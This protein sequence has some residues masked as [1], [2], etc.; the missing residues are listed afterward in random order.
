MKKIDK[1]I[2]DRTLTY[3]QKNRDY[4]NSVDKTRLIFGKQ[5]DLVR[6]ADKIHRIEQLALKHNE[7]KVAESIE[8]TILDLVVYMAIYDSGKER[9]DMAMMSTPDRLCDLI[10]SLSDIANYPL[11]A[12]YDLQSELGQEILPDFTVDYITNYIKVMTQE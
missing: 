1:F 10:D 12:L 3:L 5:S 2:Y 8:D 4:G 6:M 9:T 11:E 7:P